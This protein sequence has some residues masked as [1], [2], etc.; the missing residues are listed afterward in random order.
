MTGADAP[1]SLPRTAR[2]RA[3]L[4]LARCSNLPTCL[5]NTLV[6]TAIAL[7]AG[8]PFPWWRWAFI[9]VAIVCLY[10]AGM[11]LNDIVDR[12]VDRDERGERPIPSGRVTVRAAALATML[13][14][15]TGVAIGFSC[16]VKTGLWVLALVIAIVTYNAIHQRTAAAI[17]VMGLC[18]GLVYV[19]AWSAAGGIAMKSGA[20]LMWPALGMT[21]YVAVLSLV[22]RRECSLPGRRLRPAVL[23]LPIA[24]LWPLALLTDSGWGAVGVVLAAAGLVAGWL[25]LSARHLAT[26]SPANHHGLGCRDRPDRRRY[27]HRP[28]SPR[29]GRSGRGFVPADTCGPTVGFRGHKSLLI[30]RKRIVERGLREVAGFPAVAAAA[31]G[32]V[33]VCRSRSRSAI[34]GQ[35]QVYWGIRVSRRT[36]A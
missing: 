11:F 35:R 36:V 3:W 2:L 13:L 31:R 24:G 8:A 1:D 4:E 21:G 22:A 25:L 18:R 32:A 19:V 23:L 27:P 10:T 29:G 15:V 9:S 28:R 16:D 6:G 7:P 26:P 14:V 33:G 34:G 17:G 12:E 20:S 30:V 5:S